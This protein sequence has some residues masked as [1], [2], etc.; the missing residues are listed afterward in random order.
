MS[1]AKPEKPASLEAPAVDLFGEMV[2]VRPMP[3]T[4]ARVVNTSAAM[5]ADPPDR[6]DFLHA[7]LC[8]VGM[9]RKATEGRLFE[10]SSGGAVM[11]LEA[12]A[13]FDGKKLVNRPLPY[14]TKPRLVM[15]HMSSEAVRTQQ[16]RIHVGD[17]MKEFL[18]ALGIDTS[19]GSHGGYTM[20]KKQMEAL[21]ACRLTLGLSAGGRALTVNTQ[22]I[23]RFEAWLHPTGEQRALWPGTLELSQEFYDTLTAHAVPLDH[24]ALA[25]L[26]HSALA[27]DV[28]SWLAHRL[29]RV[30]K[31]EGVKV[32]WDNLRDQFGQEYSDPK[33]FKKEFRQVLRQAMAVYPDANIAD[34]PGGFILKPS[35]PPLAKTQVTVIA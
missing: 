11:R 15:V 28:Y 26:K 3:P 12:G 9:P 31:V 14:G 10:R 4:L 13:I 5:L 16:R 7:I 33:N 23:S 29:C 20:F 8:Q 17:S 6:A 25:A 35:R 27:L 19:G 1:K 21:A 18:I 24:R 34:T 2:P 32:S 22:P 30:R